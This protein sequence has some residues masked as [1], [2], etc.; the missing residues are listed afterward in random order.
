MKQLMTASYIV[1][2]HVIID[3]YVEKET[4]KLWLTNFKDLRHL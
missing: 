3:W 2:L 1:M 4:G